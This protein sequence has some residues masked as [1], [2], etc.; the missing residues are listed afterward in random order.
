MGWNY[1]PYAAILHITA[2][3]S[4]LVAFL[5]SFR[6]STAGANSLLLLMLAIAEW[7]LAS[8]LEAAS[9]GLGQKILWAKVEYLGAVLAPT[10][11]MIFTLEYRQ[12]NR[13]LAPPYLFL[14]MFIPLMAL[15]A[16]ITNEWHGLIWSS[17]LAGPEGSN[18]YIFVHGV[19][20]YVLIGYDYLVVLAAVIILGTGWRRA[21]HPYR[22]QISIVLA[23]SL[24]PILGGLFYV[25]NPNVL[26]GLD[27]PPITFLVTGV[28]ISVGIFKFRLFDLVPIARHAIVE[29]MSE[30]VLVLDAQGRLADINPAAEKLL[31]VAPENVLGKPASYVLRDWP[32]LRMCLE[33]SKD[34]QVEIQVSDDLPRYFEVR[35]RSL[36]NLRK[37]PSGRMLVFND[38]TTRRLA[39]KELT[40]Q[41]EELDAVNRISLAIASGLDVEQ[42]IKALREQCNSIVPMDIFYVALYDEQRGLISVPLHYERGHYATGLLRDINEHPGTIGNVIRT[43]KTIYLSDQVKPV[44]GPLK[45]QP[46]TERRAKSYVGIPLTVRDKVVGVMS[47]QSYRPAAY[48]EEQIHLLE[49]V[50]VHAAIAIENARLHA[51]VQRLAIIDELTN[52]YNYRGLVELGSREVERARRFNHPLAVLF[53][54]ID[55]FRNFNNQYSHTTGNI[56]LRAVVETISNVLRTVDVFARYGGDEFVIILPETDLEGARQTAK[57]VY[58]SVAAYSIATPYGKLSVTVS[59]GVAALTDDLRDFTSLIDKANNAEHLAKEKRLGVA[60]FEEWF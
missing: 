18:S 8:G 57:K 15:I 32:A 48:R 41:N 40:R 10:L 21:R 25:F 20:F 28:I 31:N 53:F 58:D 3:L 60:V 2:L 38:I 55:D 50:A 26:P 9:V 14:Y 29:S 4:L 1:T 47:I 7:S 45:S 23:A 51:E 36:Y 46:D 49:R 17:F 24:F 11:F 35:I 37:K 33:N 16:V 5:V 34:T 12:L 59:I 22:S 27:L 30:G 54:D 56:V 6:R 52:I 13:F 43:R 39:G 42:T 19:G 44:T